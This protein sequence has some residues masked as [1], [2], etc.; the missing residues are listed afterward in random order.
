[1]TAI[2]FAPSIRGGGDPPRRRFV[3]SVMSGTASGTGEAFGLLEPSCYEACANAGF[4]LIGA[5]ALTSVSPFQRAALADHA[6][7][8][9]CSQT[10]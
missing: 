2:S 8:A 1:M 9:W 4:R 10:T 6:W 5:E 3:S 7:R